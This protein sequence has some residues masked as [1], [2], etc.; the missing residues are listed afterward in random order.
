MYL[1]ISIRPLNEYSRSYERILRRLRVL[2]F[3]EESKKYAALQLSTGNEVQAVIYD[4]AYTK[5][6][7]KDMLHI[8][9]GLSVFEGRTIEVQPKIAPILLSCTMCPSSERT[10][11]LPL[12]WVLPTDKRLWA[13]CSKHQH[14]DEFFKHCYNCADGFGPDCSLLRHARKE[15]GL[16][17]G[18]A[19]YQHILNGSC[20]CKVSDPESTF[21]VEGP[22]NEL[23][24]HYLKEI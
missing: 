5:T 11:K 7:I 2:N 19:D 16:Y 22:I 21:K 12:G 4:S 14:F 8:G 13:L 1:D 18:E 24:I 6:W 17:L 9:F 15:D 23:M 10:I 20:P 3:S